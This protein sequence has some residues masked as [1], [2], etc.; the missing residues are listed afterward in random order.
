M[1]NKWWVQYRKEFTLHQL[2]QAICSGTYYQEPEENFQKQSLLMTSV[3]SKENSTVYTS[4]KQGDHTL[5][6]LK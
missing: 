2:F 3:R 4:N 5:N 1:Q 6:R